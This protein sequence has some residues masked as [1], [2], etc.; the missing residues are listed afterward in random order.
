MQ[1]SLVYVCYKKYSHASGLY[2]HLRNKKTP[3]VVPMQ[4][5]SSARP[6][7]LLV[8]WLVANEDG[9][10]AA[11]TRLRK[12]TPLTTSRLPHFSKAS[13]VKLCQ[14]PQTTRLPTYNFLLIKLCELDSNSVYCPT[15]QNFEGAAQLNGREVSHF[16]VLQSSTTLQDPKPCQRSL[17]EQTGQQFRNCS[18]SIIKS[19][20]SSRVWSTWYSIG[21]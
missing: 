21:R 12:F 7:R 10:I 20:S 11:S 17:V 6:S 9:I 2:Q 16:R 18:P 4:L 14:L 15:V 1:P 3:E 5:V 13:D 8:L 19:S